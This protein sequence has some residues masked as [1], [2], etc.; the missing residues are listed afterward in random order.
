VLELPFAAKPE[1][2]NPA[3]VEIGSNNRGKAKK[4]RDGST[5][6]KHPDSAALVKIGITTGVALKIDK[7][8]D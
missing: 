8:E 5:W 3:H 2:D 6:V 4:I 1:P 7:N